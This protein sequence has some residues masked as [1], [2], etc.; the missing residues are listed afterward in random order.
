MTITQE[1]MSVICVMFFDSYF[2]DL[3]G[4]NLESGVQKNI[5]SDVEIVGGGASGKS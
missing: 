2:T 4:T 3:P 5:H 1:R